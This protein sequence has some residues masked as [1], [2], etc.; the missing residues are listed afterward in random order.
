MHW[1]FF[2]SIDSTNNYLKHHNQELH[3]QTICVTKTQ[4]QG[5][6]RQGRA[7]LD[8]GN[9]CLFSILLKENLTLS[10]VEFSPLLA[11][12]S[13]HKVLAPLINHLTI[14]WPNDLLVNDKKIAGILAESII[15]NQQVCALI[16]GVGI[17]TN[18]Q[19]LPI[20]IA[21]IATS[22]FIET[23]TIIDH[24]LIINKIFNVLKDAIKTFIHHPEI[25]LNY[26]NTHTVLEHPVEFIY[27]NNVING[28]AKQ[29][30]SDGSL[31][32]LTHQGLIAYK[33]GEITLLKKKTLYD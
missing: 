33:S 15:E 28:I 17:N 7:W 9:S 20:E 13:V 19:V 14:K 11:A 31:E 32:I 6:G 23:H 2:E 24:D 16:I 8:D 29:I 12:Y 10:I 26:L 22:L 1:I 30:L 25:I 4:S 27:Q 3:H 21:P 18:M 5:H